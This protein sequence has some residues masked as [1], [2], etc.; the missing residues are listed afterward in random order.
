MDT[1]VKL[2]WTSP[3][4]G[5][6]LRMEKCILFTLGEMLCGRMEYGLRLKMSSLA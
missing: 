4:D 5:I 1:L 6:C 2:S 3:H